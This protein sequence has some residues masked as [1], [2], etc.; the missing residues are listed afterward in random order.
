MRKFLI[1]SSIIGVIIAC[2][3]VKKTQE[4]I[5]R[6]RILLKNQDYTSHIVILES[7]LNSLNEKNILGIIDERERNIE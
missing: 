3:G 2:S 6:I 7:R 1:L 4:A 5:N